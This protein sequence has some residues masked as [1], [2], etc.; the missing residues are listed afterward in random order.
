MDS[1]V[2][3]DISPCDCTISD[4]KPTQIRW[5]PSTAIFE[6]RPIGGDQWT[7]MNISGYEYT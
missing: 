1:N 2:L 4:E 7:K 6:L 5:E 3:A